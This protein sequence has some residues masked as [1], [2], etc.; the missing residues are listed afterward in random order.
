MGS[1]FLAPAVSC[2]LLLQTVGPT[3]FEMF[4]RFLGN[5]FV[6]IVFTTPR[7]DS[8]CIGNLKVKILNLY[9]IH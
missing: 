7:A 4:F 6:K 5:I 3:F 8:V 9:T 2:S 1:F